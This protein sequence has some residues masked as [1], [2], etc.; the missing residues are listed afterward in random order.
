IAPKRAMQRKKQPKP[1]DTEG[2]AP[3]APGVA[4]LP[5]KAREGGGAEGDAGGVSHSSVLYKHSLG[6][7]EF[8]HVLDTGL[9]PVAAHL[10][11]PERHRRVHHLV[12]VHPH[13][14]RTDR[15]GH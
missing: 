2:P 14:A 3:P 4:P 15:S 8:V 9:A 10:V 1:R 13:R 5:P 7:E 6:V 12:A 11:A